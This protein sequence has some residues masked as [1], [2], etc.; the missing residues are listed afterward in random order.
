MG[1][2][3][4][5]L[6]DFERCPRRFYYVSERRITLKQ[7]FLPLSQRMGSY[8]HSLISRIPQDIFFSEEEQVEKRKVEVIHAV[9][10]ELEM[11]PEGTHEVKY[12]RELGKHVVEGTL[13]I[14]NNNWFGE[15]KL[16][17]R[18]EFYLHSFT[19]HAQLEF[20]FFI[21]PCTESSMLPVRIPQLQYRETKEDDETYL[22][23]L[24]LDILRRPSFYFPFYNPEKNPKWGLKFYRHEFDLEDT[25]KRLKWNLKEIEMCRKA[26]YWPQRKAN[27]LSPYECSYLRLC[28]TGVFNSTIYEEVQDEDGFEGDV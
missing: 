16:T 25:E 28:E 7:Q 6:V 2:R 12:Q 11:I 19:A 23:R 21:S 22:S 13:D 3:R 27:C 8:L 1:I 26:E 4:S 10:V 14:V 15:I 17:S 20:Y 18:P 9:M 5:Y 24:R